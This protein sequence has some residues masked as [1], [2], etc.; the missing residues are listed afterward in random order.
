[1]YDKTYD[2]ETAIKRLAGLLNLDTVKAKAVL[3]IMCDY[4]ENKDAKQDSMDDNT[5]DAPATDVVSMFKK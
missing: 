3:E 4:I 2:S 1:M 5:E